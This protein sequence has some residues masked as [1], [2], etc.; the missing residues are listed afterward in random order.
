M[1]CLV[2]AFTVIDSDEVV[3]LLEVGVEKDG[4]TIE[5]ELEVMLPDADVK[6]LLEEE[7]S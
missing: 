2:D 7:N 6:E 1:L 3:N 4:S 5:D